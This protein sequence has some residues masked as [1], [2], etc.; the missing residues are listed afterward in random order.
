MKKN[1]EGTP[2]LTK[3]EKSSLAVM[4]GTRITF[5]GPRADRLVIVVCAHRHATRCGR[6]CLRMRR[7][8]AAARHDSD[9][10]VSFATAWEAGRTPR[11]AFTSTVA[12]AASPRPW[13]LPC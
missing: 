2:S 3:A 1:I 5:F 10:T 7:P 13:T 11:V 6:A 8:R 4:G 9:E 12:P